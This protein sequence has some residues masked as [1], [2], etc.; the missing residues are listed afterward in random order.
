MVGDKGSRFT[1]EVF[2]EFCTARNI[3]SQAA[4]PGH[5]QS[6]GATERRRGLLRTIIDHAI[7]NRKPN[8]LGRKE[9]KEFSAMTTMRLNPQVRQFGGFATGQSVFGRTP[10]M[11]I[12]AVCNPHFEDF[13]NP[14][15]ARETET[16]HLLGGGFGKYDNHR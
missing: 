4:I 3:I 9:W 1:G 13:A 2:Q 8:S 6:L 5:R 14:K 7:G 15:E 10:E 12:G 11:P 16:H